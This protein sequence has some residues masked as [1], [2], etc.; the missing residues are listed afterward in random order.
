MRVMN[1]RMEPMFIKSGTAVADLHPVMVGF[2]RQ[3][4]LKDS[5]VGHAL[6]LV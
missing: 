1:V 6:T 2:S 4:M 5:G 3:E